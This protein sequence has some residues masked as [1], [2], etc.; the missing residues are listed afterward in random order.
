VLLEE[1][2]G[3][4][5]A[6]HGRRMLSYF[7]VLFVLTFVLTLVGVMFG[8]VVGLVFGVSSPLFV[9]G[10]IAVVLTLFW[11]ISRLSLMLPAAALGTPMGPAKAWAETAE[12][13]GAILLAGL[14]LI[15]FSALGAAVAVLIMTQVSILIGLI[16]FGVLQWAYTMVGISI[17]TT[18]YGIAIEGREI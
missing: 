9:I 1:G 3:R 5:P 10:I 11:A 13:S 15:F 7:F 4:L 18:I 17:L 12:L 2:G 8:V 6:F 16:L 14:L